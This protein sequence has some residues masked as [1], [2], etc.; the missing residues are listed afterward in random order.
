[1]LVAEQDI[2]RDLPDLH[3]RFN[4]NFAFTFSTSKLSKHI[5]E[6]SKTFR[7]F[8]EAQLQICYFAI[9][10]RRNIKKPTEVPK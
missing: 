2:F 1:M 10:K 8:I 5:T 4:F 7:R 9:M 3:F 6:T